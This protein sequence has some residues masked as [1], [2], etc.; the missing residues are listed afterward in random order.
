MINSIGM[1]ESHEEYYVLTEKLEEILE[2][3]CKERTA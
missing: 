1:D 3:D 2:S